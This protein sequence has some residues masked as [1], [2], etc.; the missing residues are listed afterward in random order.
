MK[1]CLTYGVPYD[2]II[3]ESEVSKMVKLLYKLFK[4][5]KNKNTRLHKQFLEIQ[6]WQRQMYNFKSRQE[7]EMR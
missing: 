7:K 4:T 2:I 5:R 1:K 6:K 3:T